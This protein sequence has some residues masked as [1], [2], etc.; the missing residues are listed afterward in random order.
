MPWSGKVDAGR[1]A[2]TRAVARRLVVALATAAVLAACSS[3]PGPVVA[4]Q[5]SA[6][7]TPRPSPATA[8]PV[9]PDVPIYDATLGPVAP[10]SPRPVRLD[11]PDVA[12]GMPVDPVGVLDDGEMAIPEDANRAGWYEFGP[13][14]SDPTGSTVVA[15][16]VDSRQTGIGQ[17]AKLRKLGVG[18]SITVTTEDGVK[19]VYAVTSVEK[20]AKAGAPVSQWFDRSGA[21]RLVLVTC[22]G[23]WNRA[24]GHYSDNVVVTAEPIGG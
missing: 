24:I 22:G 7:A 13:T 10:P 5:P 17:F 14:P 20:I 11:V 3:G 15:G 19:H 12:I 9:V 4:A 1:V 21:P 2:P 23:A 18:A 16:H 6:T 8:V